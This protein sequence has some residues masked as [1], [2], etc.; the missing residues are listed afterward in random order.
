M[1]DPKSVSSHLADGRSQQ[2]IV[3]EVLWK[4]RMAKIFR[5]SRSCSRGVLKRQTDHQPCMLIQKASLSS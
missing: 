2:D 1:I 5:N 4:K 3:L